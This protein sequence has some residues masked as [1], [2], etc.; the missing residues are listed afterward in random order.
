MLSET[1]ILYM[2]ENLDIPY[3]KPKVIELVNN[4]GVESFHNTRVRGCSE[5]CVFLFSKF[6]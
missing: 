5:V 1:L 2:C 6:S 3:T 4:G